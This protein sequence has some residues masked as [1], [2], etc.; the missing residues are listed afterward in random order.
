M[1]STLMNTKLINANGCVRLYTNVEI[2]LKIKA[3]RTNHVQHVPHRVEYAWL[4]QL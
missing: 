3:A 2:I 4:W 1:I